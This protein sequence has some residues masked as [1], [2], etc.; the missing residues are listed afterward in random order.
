MSAH[1]WLL[2][3]CLLAGVAATEGHAATAGIGT[4][5]IRLRYERWE[6]TSP[7]AASNLLRRIGNPVLSKVASDGR[8]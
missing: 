1:G 2:L 8:R 4:T 7:A 6:L 5:E 3:P